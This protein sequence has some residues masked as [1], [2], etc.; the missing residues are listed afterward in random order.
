M[1]ADKN[2]TFIMWALRM[3][4]LPQLLRHYCNNAYCEQVQMESLI[5]MTSSSNREDW[6]IAFKIIQKLRKVKI[7]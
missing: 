2:N 5:K 4:W 7:P 3:Y 6:Y 1:E